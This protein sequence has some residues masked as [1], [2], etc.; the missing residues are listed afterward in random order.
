[1]A[2]ALESVIQELQS[3]VPTDDDSEN[4]GRLYE[5]FKEFRSMT[6]RECVMPAM[7]KL[8]ERFPNA[9]FG[10]PGPLVH[11]LEAIAGYEPL[12]RESLDRQP[13]RLTVWMANR[14]LNAKLPQEQ[15]D[16]WLNQLRLALEHPCSP[17]STRGSA[18]DYL[19]YQ[20]AA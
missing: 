19:E 6:G 14:I 7:F 5:I 18:R 16:I 17:D 3:F 9:E 15:R 20:G 2:T 1:M 10:S 4:V 8:L 11:E 12:L 13:T